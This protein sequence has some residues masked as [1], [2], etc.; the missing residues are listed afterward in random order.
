MAKSA[1]VAMQHLR[2]H[3]AGMQITMVA[4]MT[5]MQQLQANTRVVVAHISCSGWSAGSGTGNKW[6]TL[7]PTQNDRLE[8]QSAGTPLLHATELAASQMVSPSAC[9]LWTWLHAAFCELHAA[10]ADPHKAG[11]HKNKDCMLAAQGLRMICMQA[12]V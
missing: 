1:F 9:G 12:A 5:W 11:F 4:C 7:T 3:L 8:S 10:L 2:L 6:F